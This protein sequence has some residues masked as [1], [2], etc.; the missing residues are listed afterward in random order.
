M[1]KKQRKY[2]LGRKVDWE[3]GQK[4]IIRVQ[5][6]KLKKE[7]LMISELSELEN[8]VLRAGNLIN[9]KK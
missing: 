3:K 9:E 4:I 8:L 2:K 5:F 1:N 7:E 6:Q